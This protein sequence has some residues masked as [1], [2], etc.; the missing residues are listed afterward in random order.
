LL[1]MGFKIDSNI[2]FNLYRLEY[3]SLSVIPGRKSEEIT[4]EFANRPVQRQ[5]SVYT[6]DSAAAVEHL[7][8]DINGQAEGYQGKALEITGRSAALLFD[9]YIPTGS[10]SIRVLSFWLNPV[11]IDLFPKTR[12]EIQLF[13]DKGIQYDYK[14]EMMGR[15]IKTVDGSWGLIEYRIHLVKPGSRVRIAAYN[16]QIGKK[17]TYRIDEL[18]IR[19]NHCNVYYS[20]GNYRSKN[21]RWFYSR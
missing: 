11:D 2:Y 19:P 5:D 3:D 8:F 9:N 16:T 21:N 1:N 18:L 17:L 7:N 4:K 14:N 10:D 15:F 20:H 6:S 12:L 13:N